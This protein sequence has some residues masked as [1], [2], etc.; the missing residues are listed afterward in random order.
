MIHSRT[1]RVI[2]LFGLAASAAMTHHAALAQPDASEV[3][4]RPNLPLRPAHTY[5]IVARDPASGQLGA[6]VQ[7][8]W[9]SVGADVIWAQPGV[10]AVATQSFIEVSYGPLGLAMM[11]SGNTAPQTLTSLLAKDEHKNVRQIG[12][13]DAKGNTAVHTGELAI[14]A[15]CHLV[16]E[17]FTVQANLMEKDTVCAAMAAAFTANANEDLA[18]RMMAALQAAQQE[19]G[20]IRGKQSAA[21]LVVEGEKGTPVWQGRL[22]DLR[23]EDNADP[24]SELSR[25]LHVSRTYSKMTEGDDFMTLGKIDEALAAYATAESMMPDNHEAIF[26][27]AAT[28]A[29]VD[30]VEESL[31]LFKK[32]FALHPAWKTLVPRLPASELL[33]DDP[34]IINRILAVK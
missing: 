1:L 7:S 13:I 25:L 8:H 21:M 27:H 5:S 11:E 23:V 12:M 10:G 28:L 24:I 31:P 15:H 32:A 16:G 19:G 6:A 22:V 30:R 2:T 34:K 33:P 18:G 4:Q 26:W 3:Y 29:A 17:D 20:D 14:T 9:F